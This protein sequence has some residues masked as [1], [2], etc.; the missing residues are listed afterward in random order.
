MSKQIAQGQIRRKDGKEYLVTEDTSS[1]IFNPDETEVVEMRDLERNVSTPHLCKRLCF[2]ENELEYV[3]DSI[4]A[5]VA[6]WNK[7]R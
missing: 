7:K 6:S 1:P 3:A 4:E 2:D 5:W